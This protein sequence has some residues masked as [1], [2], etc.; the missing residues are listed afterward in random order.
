MTSG[1]PYASPEHV[2]QAPTEQRRRVGYRHVPAAVLFAVSGFWIVVNLLMLAS[3]ATEF[4]LGWS[5][6]PGPRI[7]G[8]ILFLLAGTTWIVA[9][10][11]W[12]RRRWWY[13][14]LLT[15][16]GYLMGTGAGYLVFPQLP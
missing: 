12:L 11:Y 7:A 13:A 1:N 16:V 4:V 3:F 14:V 8:C 2:E 6:L 5:R 10:R 15:V 9:G